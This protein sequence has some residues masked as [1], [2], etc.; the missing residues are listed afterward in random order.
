MISIEHEGNLT[1]ATVFG[2]FRIADY[3]E[4]EDQIAAQLR[5]T[6]KMNLL[7]DLRGM[8]SYTIDVALE[9]IKFAR[10]HAHDMGK[11]AIISER[12]MVAWLA[13]LTDLFVDAEIKVF[14]EEAIARQWLEKDGR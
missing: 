4:F 6:G 11:I 5:R 7:V 1:I 3:R 8:L 2:E 9:D 14:D 10:E 13:L 12:E